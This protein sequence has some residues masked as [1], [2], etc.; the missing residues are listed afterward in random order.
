VASGAANS[1]QAE[2]GFKWA[3]TYK[4]PDGMV[5]SPQLRAGLQ[6]DLSANSRTIAAN[7]ALVP[8]GTNFLSSS[9]KPDQTSAVASGALKARIDTRLDFFAAVSGRFSGNQSEGTISIG[10]AYRF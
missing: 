4:Q 1:T 7:L 6:Q 8:V 2:I 5:L 3:A 9:T 10:G